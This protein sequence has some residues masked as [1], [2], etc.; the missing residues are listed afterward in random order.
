MQRYDVSNEKRH[1]SIIKAFLTELLYM[2]SV[3][4][5]NNIK[6][7]ENHLI[8]FDIRIFLLLLYPY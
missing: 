5:E 8:L 7:A 4:Q 6:N 1:A 2:Y 3:L